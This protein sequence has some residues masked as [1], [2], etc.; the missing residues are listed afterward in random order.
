MKKIRTIP[1]LFAIVAV[2][3]LSFYQVKDN[4]LARA[5]RL[6]GVYTFVRCEP[7][8]GYEVVG[9]M[10]TGLT[11]ALVGQQKMK[12]LLDELISRAN[13]RVEKKKWEKFDGVITEDGY[14]GTFI[15]FKE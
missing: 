1:A 8:N 12:D 3:L 7:L 10:D 4:S 13:K 15:K 14:K 11:S 2:S 6:Q 9:N 5:D